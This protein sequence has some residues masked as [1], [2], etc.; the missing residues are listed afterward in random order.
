MSNQQ[1]EFRIIPKNI[2]DELCNKFHFKQDTMFSQYRDIPSIQIPTTCVPNLV[3]IDRKS[4]RLNS[5]HAE[6]S[7]MPSSA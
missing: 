5:S 2:S 3:G 6:L 4:T 7:R 1:M